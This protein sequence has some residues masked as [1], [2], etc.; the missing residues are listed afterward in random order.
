MKNYKYILITLLL[1]TV[2]LSCSKFLEEIDKDKFIPSTV[3]HYAALMLQEF[4]N[5]TG[6]SNVFQLMT[7]E[8]A[9]ANSQ[10]IAAAA[11]RLSMKPIYTWQKDIEMNENGLRV[12]N[13]AAWQA[14]YRRIAIVNYVIEEV[15]GAE[16][17]P[18][19]IAFTKGEAYFIR[20][21]CY[22][23]LTNLYAEP[24]E[25]PEQARNTYGV[26]LRTNIAVLPTYDKDMLNE[27]YELIEADLTE[28]RRLIENSGI[29]NKSLYHPKVATCDLM[30]STVKLYKKEYQ[31][32][33][34]AA[35]KVIEKSELAR[36]V[37]GGGS[38][39]FITLDNPEVLYSFQQTPVAQTYMSGQSLV[40]DPALYGS[41]HSNDQR[42][43]YFFTVSVNTALQETSVYPRKSN[44]N[45][46]NL[47]TANMRTAE[48]YLNRAEAY[49]F[50]GQYDKAREDLMAL[51]SKRYLNAANIQIPSDNAQL[52]GFIF[53]ERLKELCFEQLHRWFDLRR[54][55]ESLRPEIV[56]RFSITDRDGV[57]EGTEFFT[58]LKNDRNYTLS[59][60]YQEKENNLFI[61]DYDRFDKVAE[62]YAGEINF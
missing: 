59:V 49:A 29:T 32:V 41:Y 26:P 17:S 37:S 14:L 13:N 20:A 48:A 24:Y 43:S 45:Y 19:E 61:R 42:R 15:D 51:L 25:N 54:M 50:T 53:Q 2:S 52:I 31:G 9:E 12:G 62:Y 27:C 38:G 23:Y 58:L 40:V 18:E 44:T 57:L 21:F 47:R 60:P 10:R 33:I 46:S 22:F 11:N 5:N 4:N 16:G 56:H 34:D 8:V 39:Y 55:G 36:M 3:D 6:I 28:A 35:T 7:D 30:L 1:S